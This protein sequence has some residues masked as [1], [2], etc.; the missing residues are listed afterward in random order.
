MNLLLNGIHYTWHIHGS[1]LWINRYHYDWHWTTT[2]E[3]SNFIRLQTFNLIS[4]LDRVLYVVLCG[5]QPP[6]TDNQINIKLKLH[7]TKEYDDSYFIVYY[8]LWYVIKMKIVFGLTNAIS[9]N[10]FAFTAHHKNNNKLCIENG[11][12]Y[13]WYFRAD[14][15]SSLVFV[16]DGSIRGTKIRF[17]NNNLWFWRNANTCGETIRNLYQSLHWIYACTGGYARR[18]SFAIN[19]RFKWI[20]RTCTK[21]INY[22]IWICHQTSWKQRKS[23]PL[24]PSC[25]YAKLRRIYYTVIIIFSRWYFYSISRNYFL[26]HNSHALYVSSNEN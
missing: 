9:V 11:V 2:N 16:Y 8:Y 21:R 20:H 17:I 23:S 10:V 7:R 5:W 12:K 26:W 25:R 18:L 15:S 14:K 1:W 6:K 4:T 3:I 22:V 19:S 24:T 13:L